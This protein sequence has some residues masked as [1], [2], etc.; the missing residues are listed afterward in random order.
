MKN[1]DVNQSKTKKAKKIPRCGHA[2]ANYLA[3][4]IKINEDGVSRET[5]MEELV[6]RR[7]A[8]ERFLKVEGRPIYARIEADKYE[9]IMRPLWKENKQAKRRL[10]CIYENKPYCK[11][12]DCDSCEHPVY[13]EESIDR[14]D[15]LGGIGLPSTADAAEVS[16][17]KE[18]YTA[19]YNA[20]GEL[21]PTDWKILLMKA[22]DKSER[23]IAE[24]L[25]YRSKTSIVK[26]LEHMIPQLREKLKNYF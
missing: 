1:H 3:E 22:E 11:G 24:A 15:G 10:A 16:E 18:K 2:S 4:P 9:Q 14:L 23:E 19:L 7:E 12:K 5:T 8:G 6:K 21:D 20:V 26:R 17:H 25:G 13:A